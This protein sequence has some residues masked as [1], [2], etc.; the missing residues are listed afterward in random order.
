MEIVRI[1]GENAADF[2]AYI[3]IEV[4]IFTKSKEGLPVDFL[5]QVG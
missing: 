1:T 3:D 4:E 2:S 5:K